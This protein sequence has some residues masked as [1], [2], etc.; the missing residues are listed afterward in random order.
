MAG[1]GLGDLPRWE[2]RDVIGL[3][4]DNGWHDVEN[5]VQMACTV[6]AESGCF[7]HAWHWNDPMDGGNGST[8]WGMFQLNDGNSGGSAPSV[9]SSG[10]PMAT[11]QAQRDAL[12][13]AKA[14]VK[15]RSM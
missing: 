2:Y 14:V 10:L 3:L 6:D 9:S 8:D 11:T 7:P 15:A 1:Y 13:P 12:D 4:Y 5:L